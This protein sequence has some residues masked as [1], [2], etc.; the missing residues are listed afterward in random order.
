MDEQEDVVCG[1][2]GK[3]A[4]GYTHERSVIFVDGAREFGPERI[5][6]EPC[7]CVVDFPE[8]A[9]EDGVDAPITVVDDNTQII[10][11]LIADAVSRDIVLEFVDIFNLEDELED[12]DDEE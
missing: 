7:K 3:K 12:I 1:F 5:I 10:P 4:E 11:V 2:C 8:F 9:Y 6:V